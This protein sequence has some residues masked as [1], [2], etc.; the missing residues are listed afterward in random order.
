MSYLLCRKG[1]NAYYYAHGKSNSEDEFKVYDNKPLK[2][3]DDLD[4]TVR[5]SKGYIKPITKYSWADFKKTVRVYITLDGL[6]EVIENN[7]VLDYKPN[8]K[9]VNLRINAVGSTS[10]DHELVLNNLHEK[11]TKAKC[12]KKDGNRLVL[13][14]YKAEEKTW[15]DLQ[16]K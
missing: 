2:L 13:F 12:K 15:Y 1:K 3:D 9:A 6:N 7:I 16:L 14:L 4:K 5:I 11:I 10:Q 8:S